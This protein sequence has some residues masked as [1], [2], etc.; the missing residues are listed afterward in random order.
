MSNSPFHLA[1]KAV[2]GA[3]VMV[4]LALGPAAADNSLSV[5]LGGQT[6]H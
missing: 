1:R 2:T 3:C 4:L 5:I 6:R